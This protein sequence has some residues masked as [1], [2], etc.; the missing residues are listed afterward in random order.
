MTLHVYM[1]AAPK[2]RAALGRARLLHLGWALLLLLLLCSQTM[3]GRPWLGVLRGAGWE[4]GR[5]ADGGRVCLETASLA[6]SRRAMVLTDSHFDLP[7]T[8]TGV[9]NRNYVRALR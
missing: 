5:G 1:S 9:R 8:S 3:T 4:R 2:R 7:G 6:K